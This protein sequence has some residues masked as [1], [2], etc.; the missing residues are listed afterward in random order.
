VIDVVLILVDAAEA[1]EGNV[2]IV[3]SDEESRQVATRVEQMGNARYQISFV[4]QEALHH[5]IDVTFNKE[6]VPG[7]PF[8]VDIMDASRVQ[9]VGEG[10]RIAQV[11]Q[12]ATFQVITRGAGNEAVEVAIEGPDGRKL[13]A[14]LMDNRDQTYTVEYIAVMA[15][16]FI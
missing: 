1:G 10:L 16:T 7:T 8:G 14:R 13:P 12:V 15:G 6:P 3:V 4:A 9:V 2:E 11:R 5:R